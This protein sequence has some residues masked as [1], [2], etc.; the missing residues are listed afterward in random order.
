MRGCHTGGLACAPSHFPG[1]GGAS[2]D[3]AQG[4]AT[5]SLDSASLQ[6]RDVP[7]FAAAFEAGA[8]AVVLS[9]ALYA[10][11][12][13]VTPGALSPAIATDL[14]RGELGY[15]G[16]AI[17]DDLSSGAVAAG[18]GAPDAAVRALRAGADMVV[19]SDPEQA[20]RAR[21]AVLEAATAGR[22]SP[23]RLDEAVAR[24]LTL[25][26]RRGLYTG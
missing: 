4:P 10:T 13:P 24:V 8:P 7:P 5:V 23:A 22:L 3:T 12:D 20:A 26:R 25:K 18:I 1:L 16:V 6:A 11:Y 21:Q 9:L 14:L 2:A 17:T 15:E 19:V